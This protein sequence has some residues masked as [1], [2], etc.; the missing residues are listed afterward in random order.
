MSPRRL[1]QIRSWIS[2]CSVAAVCLGAAGCTQALLTGAYLIRGMETTPEF[3]ELKGKK[4]AVVC[5]PIVEL[6]YSSSDA[7]DRLARE[8]GVRIKQRVK[9]AVVV[10]GQKVEEWADEHDWEEFKEIGKALKTDYVVGIDLEEFSLYQGQTI[11]Q[12]RARVHVTVHEIGKGGEKVFDKVLKRIVYP[13]NSGVATSDKTE[14]E[15]SR[16]FTAVVA[17][18]IGRCFYSFDHRDD[19]AMDSRVLD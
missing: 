8:V 18:Q 14:E 19:F 13:P 11:Y 1:R 5:R 4:T 6:Q 3:N 12:G 16:E 7:A 2:F 15:F 9:K 17:E 10:D